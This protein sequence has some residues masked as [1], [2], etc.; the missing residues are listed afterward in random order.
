[1]LQHGIGSVFL[2]I[3]I[4]IVFVLVF[5]FILT[6]L[7]LGYV[8]R[9]YKVVIGMLFISISIGVF[10]DSTLSMSLVPFAIIL[11]VF[12]LFLMQKT[13]KSKQT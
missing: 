10:G 2:D 5:I 3:E 1:M 13:V 8:Y 11:C 12:I 7:G 9:K 6:V 4:E